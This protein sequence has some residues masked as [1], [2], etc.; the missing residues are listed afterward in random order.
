MKR[1]ILILLWMAAPFVSA[2]TLKVM[3][4]N[5]RLSVDSDQENSWEH[6]KKETMGL[7]SYYHPDVLGVQEALPQQMTDLKATLSGYQTV[8]VGRDDGKNK[9]EFSAIFYD[10]SRLKL[11]QSGTFWLSPTP[12]VPSKGWDA[13]L[14]RICTYALLQ[15]KKS[16]KK[17]W[18]FN[19][20]FDHVGDLARVNSAKLILEKIQKMNTQKLPVVL[21]GDFN[22]TADT[23]PLKVLAAAMSDTQL[24]SQTPHYGPLGTFQN[25]DVTT[26]AKDRIDYIFT[27]NF[28]VLSNRTIN[29]RR[30]N[31]LYPSDHFPVMAELKFPFKYW[32]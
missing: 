17:F 26:P 22:L 30:E 18:A 5:I 11:L 14:N 25:F 27:N 1:F 31:L 16:G 6:R 20:H 7:I 2:Q 3:T 23:E 4:F 12:E 29:D 24:H 28:D 8:G 13:A 21:T 32:K 9:G 19:T 10:E 15:E